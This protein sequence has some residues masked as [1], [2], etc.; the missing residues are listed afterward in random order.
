M[1]ELVNENW[2]LEISQNPEFYIYYMKGKQ[3]NLYMLIIIFLNVML[4]WKTRELLKFLL[5]N[6]Y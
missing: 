3:K 5:V 6:A 4:T 1:I 2:K